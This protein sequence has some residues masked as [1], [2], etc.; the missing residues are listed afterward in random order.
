M[1]DQAEEGLTRADPDALLFGFWQA[2]AHRMQAVGDRVLTEANR[3]GDWTMRALMKKARLPRT[4]KA[5][6]QA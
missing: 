5:L 4:G 2:D 3:M 1:A 6:A